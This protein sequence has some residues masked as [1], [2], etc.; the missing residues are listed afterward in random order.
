MLSNNYKLYPNPSINGSLNIAFAKASNKVNITVYNML[1]SLVF[2][3]QTTSLDLQ[4]ASSVYS[5]KISK[6]QDSTIKKFIME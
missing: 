5:I 6:E 1:G 4:L 2:S 3:T